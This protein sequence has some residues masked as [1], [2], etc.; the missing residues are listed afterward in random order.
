MTGPSSDPPNRPWAPRHRP[1]R[2]TLLP[3]HPTRGRGREFDGRGIA[4]RVLV[5]AAVFG[6]AFLVFE[7]IGTAVG[8]PPRW[9]STLGVATFMLTLRF[10]QPVVTRLRRRFGDRGDPRPHS[11]SVLHWSEDHDWSAGC[12]KVSGWTRARRHLTQASGCAIICLVLG[13]AAL[14]FASGRDEWKLVLLGGVVAAFAL[15]FF[16]THEALWFGATRVVFRNPPIRPGETVLLEFAHDGS[17][18]SFHT[19]AWTLRRIEEHPGEEVAGRND[20]YLTAE[21]SS[22]PY[23]DLPP[24]EPGSSVEFEV[25]LP[26]GAGG[27]LLAA[28]FPHYW[29]LEVRGDTTNGPYLERFL[30]PVYTARREDDGPGDDAATDRS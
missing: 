22:A 21:V 15:C 16:R 6:I 24:P 17:G 8:L 27:T 1:S 19:I 28:R 10:A 5:Y 20:A 9:R 12:S 29:E 18:G 30:L 7:G 2:R 4:I 3:G 23:A 13:P 14:W 11:K 26:P 25:T